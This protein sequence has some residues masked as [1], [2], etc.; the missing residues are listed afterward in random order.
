MNEI[1]RN[2]IYVTDTDENGDKHY[3]ETISDLQAKCDN[4]ENLLDSETHTRECR[5][6]RIKA[7]HEQNRKLRE[8]LEGMINR[9]EGIFFVRGFGDV[10]AADEGP[11]CAAARAALAEGETE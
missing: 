4:L 2:P 11:E 8:A 10:E 3:L 7:L 5:E 1:T 6:R 9:V